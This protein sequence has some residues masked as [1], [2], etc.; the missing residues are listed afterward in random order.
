[1][2]STMN[3]AADTVTNGCVVVPR[4]RVAPRLQSSGL[5]GA[6]PCYPVVWQRL[7]PSS[8]EGTT[9]LHFSLQTTLV[10]VY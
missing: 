2:D 4:F 3:H 1:M 7:I 6:A 8:A 10:K 5:E 9:A